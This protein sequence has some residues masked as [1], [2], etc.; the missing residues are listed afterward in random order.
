MERA[1]DDLYRL[2]SE[3]RDI[4]VPMDFQVDVG[5]FLSFAD[6]FFDNIFVDW[7][8]QSR[9]NDARDQVVEATARVQTILADLQEWE[10]RLLK[11]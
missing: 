7:M 1:K 6:M 2:Q 4:E 9:I 5:G 8:V 3:L 11:G 10:W